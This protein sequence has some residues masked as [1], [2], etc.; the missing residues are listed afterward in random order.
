MPATTVPNYLI[1]NE[2]GTVLRTDDEDIAKYHEEASLVIDVKAN[3]ILGEDK[4]IAEAE[5]DEA[6]EETEEG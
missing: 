2:G 5:G 3:T 1:V 6:N 4:Q